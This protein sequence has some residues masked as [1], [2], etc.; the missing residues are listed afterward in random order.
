MLS[1]HARQGRLPSPLNVLQSWQIARNDWLGSSRLALLIFTLT[2]AP[3]AFALHLALLLLLSP[4]LAILVV[5]AGKRGYWHEQKN[6]LVSDHG[7]AAK[8]ALAHL[9]GFACTPRVTPMSPPCHHHVP[10]NIVASEP[11]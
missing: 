4:L 6:R 9:F 2:I 11:P 3:L 5:R 8:E 1:E 10:I 7:R